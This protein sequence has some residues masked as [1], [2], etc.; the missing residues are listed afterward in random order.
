MEQDPD[1]LLERLTSR[2]QGRLNRDGT[3]ENPPAKFL[4]LLRIALDYGKKTNG[5]FDITVQ[6]LWDFRQK[7]KQAS[8][9][10]RANLE[11]QPWKKAISLVDFRNITATKDRI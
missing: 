9:P 7:W 11:K 4:E 5:L 2:D 10:L 6:P 8:L 3:L 1:T